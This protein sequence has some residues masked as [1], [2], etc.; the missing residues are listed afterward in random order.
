MKF[1]KGTSGNPAGRPR[2]IRNKSTILLEN[3]AQRNTEAVAR[4]LTAIA[5]SNK[6]VSL[7]VCMQPK[8][9]EQTDS[10]PESTEAVCE[11]LS[12]RCISK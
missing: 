12:V 1:Q 5:K 9:A 7:R 3:V 6:I 11:P 2:G 8:P 4:L 10:R